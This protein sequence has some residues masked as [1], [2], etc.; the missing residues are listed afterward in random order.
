MTNMFCGCESLLSLD[1]NIFN[2]E[3]DTS[4]FDMFRNDKNLQKL[5][6]KNFDVENCNSFGQIFDQCLN[7]T[8]IFGKNNEKFKI[9]EELFPSYVTIEYV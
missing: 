6:L 1:L 4:M 9:L 2:K 7:L 8:L 3:K 5:N